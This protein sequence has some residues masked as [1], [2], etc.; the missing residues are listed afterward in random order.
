MHAVPLPVWVGLAVLLTTLLIFELVRRNRRPRVYLNTVESLLTAAEA[1]FYKVL[2]RVVPDGCVLLTKVR[3]ADVIQVTSKHPPSRQRVFRSISSKHVDF[4]IADA[5]TL[6]PLAAIELDDSSHARRDR[7]KRDELVE[8]VFAAAD[9]PLI[10]I[11]TAARYSAGEL[12]ADLQEHVDR[13][14]VSRPERS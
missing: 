3:I 10:R 13:R 5:L 11:P 6:Q 8:R 1:R 9:L 12:A 7:R 2:Q 14:P 4:L